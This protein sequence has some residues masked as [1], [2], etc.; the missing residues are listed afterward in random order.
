MK[1]LEE[2]FWAKVDKSNPV[3]CWT[4]MASKTKFGYGRIRN[5]GWLS[6]T[7]LAHRVSWELFNGPIFGDAKCL[8]KC[9]VPSCVKPSHLFLGSLA[10]NMADK[11]KKGRGNCAPGERNGSAKLT[12]EKVTEIREIYKAGGVSQ[13]KLAKIY[14]ICRSEISHIVTRKNWKAA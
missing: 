7:L 13:R 12:E 1:T 5:E 14:G 11:V 2:R 9:D 8:H 6:K 10:D 4:W 3:G